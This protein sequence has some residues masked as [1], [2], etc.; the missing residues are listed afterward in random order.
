MPSPFCG[1]TANTADYTFACWRG[2]IG[3]GIIET[4][5]CELIRLHRAFELGELE[6]IR[7]GMNDPPEF[8]NARGP[9][10]VGHIVLEYAIY[11]S[12]MSLICTLLDLD[13]DPNYDD[14]AGFPSLIA[15]LSTT[16]PDR[17][18][19][20]ALLLERGADPD[21]R[22]LNDWTPLMYA[23]TLG[24]VAAIRLLL[25][26]GANVNL[27][28]RIDDYETAEEIASAGGHEDA[29]RALQSARSDDKTRP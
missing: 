20:L 18:D 28:T 8:P 2:P 3:V 11:H 29:R 22:G 16:R 14:H 17:L 27:R 15:T 19:V 26:Y 4:M 25:Q 1:S 12:P 23:A 6:A 9:L 5:S 24:D 13:A 21:Q 10:G 7:R